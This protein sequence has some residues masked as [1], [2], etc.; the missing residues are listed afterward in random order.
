MHEWIVE[1]S[2]WLTHVGTALSGML[3]A[4]GAGYL[5]LIRDLNFI[6]GQLTEIMKSHEALE[7]VGDN[8]D[9]LEMRLKIIES[10]IFK[11]EEHGEFS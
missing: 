10:Y 6:K 4:M 5:G 7:A 3:A 1:N 9:G 8:F 2:Y 11:G